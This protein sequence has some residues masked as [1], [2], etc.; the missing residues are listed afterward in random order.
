MNNTTYTQKESI[1][2]GYNMRR[3]AVLLGVWIAC[4]LVLAVRPDL[5]GLIKPGVGA[6]GYLHS[7]GL[8]WLALGIGGLTF[9]TVHL[10]FLRGPLC[11]LAWAAKIL[12]DPFHNIVLYWR[13]PIALLQGELLDPIIEAH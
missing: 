7:V 11:A 8:M 5:F 3:K 6:G 1:K 9:R 12:T 10:V 2:V 13:S 4:P